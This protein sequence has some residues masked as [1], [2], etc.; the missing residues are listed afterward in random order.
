MNKYVLSYQRGRTRIITYVEASS[1]EE[2]KI[3]L[4]QSILDLI[5]EY[6]GKPTAKENSELCEMMRTLETLA[7]YS[8][9]IKVRFD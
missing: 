9:D 2:A 1:L 7:V 4:S 6:V 8:P 3:G 5:S